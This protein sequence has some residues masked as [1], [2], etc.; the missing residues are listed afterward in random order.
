ME[1]NRKVLMA[2]A[3]LDGHDAGVKVICR[4]LRD[5]GMEVV[6]TG[7]RQT[8]EKI[9]AAA[10]DEDVDVIGVSILSGAHMHHMPRIMELLKENDAQDIVVILGGTIPTGDIAQLKKLGVAEV[11][12][13]DTDTSK[14]IDFLRNLPPRK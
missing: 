8:P 9:V 3:G 4:A 10:L 2:K 6:Y 5:A 1:S 14:A 13:T 7:L 11:Y 12:P